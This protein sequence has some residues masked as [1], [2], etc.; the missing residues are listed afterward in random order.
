MDA[1]NKSVQISSLDRR[2]KLGNNGGWPMP[3]LIQR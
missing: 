1:Q 2:P 3:S